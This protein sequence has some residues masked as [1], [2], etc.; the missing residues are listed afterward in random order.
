VSS[1]LPTQLQRSSPPTPTHPHHRVFTIYRPTIQFT[2]DSGAT[3]IILRQSDSHVLIDYTPYD[4][5]AFSP[6]FDV[7]NGHSIYPLGTG[8]LRVSSSN[9]RLIAYVF[10]DLDLADNLFGLAPIINLG[11]TATYSSSG[12]TIRDPKHHVVIY[13]TKHNKVWKFSLPKPPA[14]AA[15]IV[16]RHE[17]SAELV[18]YASASFGSPTYATF[19][20]AVNMGWLTNYPDL[21]PK[22]VRQ[23]KPHS[24][25]TGLGHITASRANVR[26]TRPR[27]TSSAN[28]TTSMAIHVAHGLST[29]PLHPPPLNLTEV[30][31]HYDPDDLPD[32]VLRCRVQP[33]SEF[34]R[35][36]IFSDLP[37]RFPVPAKNRTEYPLLSVYKGYIHVEP[38]V[39]RSTTLLCPVNSSTTSKFRSSTMKLQC[40]HRFLLVSKH[41]TSHRPTR[42]ETI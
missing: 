2:S 25:A 26:S 15:N 13:G 32:T 5:P 28:P 27:P 3:D 21:T 36:A 24:P 37:G 18:L 1:H 7:A 35:D 22:T 11:Y 30:L 6:R 4:D 31:H 38:L 23:N 29:E 17:Q 10:S 12:L 41:R 16:V 19:Y 39:S 9:L 33:S 42:P 8:Y 14:R 34:R 20:N 40:P